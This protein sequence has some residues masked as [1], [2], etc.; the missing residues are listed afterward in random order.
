M[1][2]SHPCLLQMALTSVYPK[3]EQGD[4]AHELN[5][6]IVSMDAILYHF[7]GSRELCI[8]SAVLRATAP[9]WKF[10]SIDLCTICQIWQIHV[11]YI[12]S[13]GT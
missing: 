7:L 13:G 10:N 2:C 9:S 6:E 12:P 4:H 8:T 5:K 11:M 3:K 1:I